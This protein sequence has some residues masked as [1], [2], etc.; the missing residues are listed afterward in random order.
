LFLLPG[1][2]GA[3]RANRACV[4]QTLKELRIYH[5]PESQIQDQVRRDRTADLAPA[6]QGFYSALSIA[7]LNVTAHRRLGQIALARGDYVTARDHLEA[8]YRIAPEERPTIQMLGEVNAILG[9]TRNALTV[10]G[11]GNADISRLELRRWWYVHLGA[12][13]EIRAINKALALYCQSV[14]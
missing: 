7:P 1:T 13:Q 11:L 14:K 2:R 12:Q 8:A 10:W 3:L 4:E 9:D 6:I 5:W